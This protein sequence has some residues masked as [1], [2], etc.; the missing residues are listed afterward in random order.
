M[1]YLSI[2]IYR[3]SW[4]AFLSIFDVF[5]ESH[6][7]VA[8]A[9]LYYTSL[10]NQTCLRSKPIDLI[11]IYLSIDIHI[12]IY[13]YI[14]IYVCMGLTHDIARQ[15]R[16]LKV[17]VKCA[18]WSTTFCNSAATIPLWLNS[19]PCEMRIISMKPRQGKKPL[20]MHTRRLPKT[21]RNSY[22]AGARMMES[23]F[24]SFV[25]WQSLN[26]F[27]WIESMSRSTARHWARY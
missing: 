3:L 12:Y 4:V 13:I 2:S 22:V 25:P 19:V 20:K 26:W 11:D 21:C 10:Q 27:A 14:Y 6:S 17:R 23:S 9:L 18:I 5:Y 7:T 24:E 1:I 15:G 16:T 8:F